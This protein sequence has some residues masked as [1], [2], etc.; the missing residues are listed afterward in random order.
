MGS[1]EHF[2]HR[3]GGKFV[4]TFRHVCDVTL[5]DEHPLREPASADDAEHSGSRCKAS[6]GGA[7]GHHCSRDF[8][9]GYIGW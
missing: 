2:R 7:A 1:D 4:K 9:P 3:G 5:V 8:D 6:S